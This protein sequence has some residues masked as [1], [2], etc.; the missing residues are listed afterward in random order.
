MSILP[1]TT[2]IRIHENMSEGKH[3]L[4]KGAVLSFNFI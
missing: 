2:A 1:R 4:I 3:F